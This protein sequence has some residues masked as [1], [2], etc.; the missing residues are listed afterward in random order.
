MTGD[1]TLDN[2]INSIDEQTLSPAEEA[3]R[4][5][6][7][8]DTPAELHDTLDHEINVGDPTVLAT[9]SQTDFNTALENIFISDNETLPPESRGERIQEF[10]QQV[11]SLPRETLDDMFDE[12]EESNPALFES[13][14]AQIDTQEAQAALAGL[15]AQGAGPFINAF[16]ERA[17]KQRTENNARRST[18][19][20]VNALDTIEAAMDWLDKNLQREYEAAKRKFI[21]AETPEKEQ[22]AANDFAKEAEQAAK[23]KG[24]SDE[25]AREAA[26]KKT[27]QMVIEGLKEKKPHWDNKQIHERAKEIMD[28]VRKD[29]LANDSSLTAEQIEAETAK[30]VQQSGD[31]LIDLSM[32]EYYT[33]ELARFK[34]QLNEL[35]EEKLVHVDIDGQ[36]YA[37]ESAKGIDPETGRL[38]YEGDGEDKYYYY[39]ENASKWVEASDTQDIEQ[40]IADG[41][42]LANDPEIVNEYITAADFVNVA[43]EELDRSVDELKDLKSQIDSMPDGVTKDYLTAKV[44]EL[45]K[46]L[47]QKENLVE[48][49][50]DRTAHLSHVIE[51]GDKITNV[52]VYGFPYN[53][54]EAPREEAENVL[55]DLKDK[56]AIAKEEVHHLKEKIGIPA[57]EATNDLDK[58]SVPF[59]LRK[60]HPVDSEAQESTEVAETESQLAPEPSE[61]LLSN[62]LSREEYARSLEGQEVTL[63]R[64][65]QDF[66]GALDSELSDIAHGIKATA[67]EEGLNINL[68]PEL[69]ELIQP[70]NDK[71]AQGP[72]L[73]QNTN[74]PGIAAPGAG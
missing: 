68:D 58:N 29:L 10:A 32:I 28:G 27:E 56:T 37:V 13:I 35:I 7:E 72:A 51:N 36:K 60:E 55:A 44:Q 24:F 2:S 6:R 16:T 9:M 62:G 11:S 43:Q 4:L 73:Q 3:T 41:R 40:Q 50:E 8:N 48:H 46:E 66:P 20:Q 23:D 59:Y 26:L 65:K 71:I 30:I 70:D 67:E 31:T 5:A 47:A 74:D 14:F 63:E 38:V 61:G 53:L 64:L 19:D 15:A 57:A 45:E 21:A 49:Y 33:T 17:E 22:E 25:A 52:D 1:K 54:E 12:L 18:A 39:D 34:M 42:L 69:K